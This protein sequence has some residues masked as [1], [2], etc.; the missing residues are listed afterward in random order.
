MGFVEF[1]SVAIS[2]TGS[3]VGELLGMSRQ[4]YTALRAHAEDEMQHGVSLAVDMY[5]VVGCKKD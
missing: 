4:Q 3:K 5:V 1:V 2:K